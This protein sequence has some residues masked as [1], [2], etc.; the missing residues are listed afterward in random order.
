ML[1]KGLILGELLSMSCSWIKLVAIASLQEGPLGVPILC[2]PLP[3]WIKTALWDWGYSEYEGGE[4]GGKGE[5]LL[6]NHPGPKGGER[7][8]SFWS[9][10]IV[11][12]GLNVQTCKWC[13]VSLS[14]SFSFL[15]G[16]T[17]FSAFISL[18]SLFCRLQIKCN[19]WSPAFLFIPFAL[20]IFFL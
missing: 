10:V 5:K 13:M 8:N 2:D 3:H 19:P 18:W 11:L 20:C 9:P 14:F 1:W 7:A 6:F 15:S 4:E 16:L 12:F 17:V